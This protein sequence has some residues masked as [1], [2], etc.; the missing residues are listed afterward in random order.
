MSDDD[1]TRPMTIEAVSRVEGHVTT[2]TRLRGFT[3]TTDEPESRGGADRGPTPTETLV[4]ALNG[5][6]VVFLHRLAEAEG[7]HVVV[8]GVTTRATFDRRGVWLIAPVACPFLAVETVAVLSAAPDPAT[9]ARWQAL[10][11]THAPLHATLHA[12]GSAVTVRLT[13]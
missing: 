12:A 4:A 9:L 1:R 11:L 6:T 13:L 2:E 3:L 8:D 10:F 5:A 7:V